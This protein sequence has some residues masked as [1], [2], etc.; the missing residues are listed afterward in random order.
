[1]LPKAEDTMVGREAAGGAT[2]TTPKEA[3]EDM[4]EDM[5][6][7]EVEEEEEEEE[8][9]VGGVAAAAEG[10]RCRAAGTVVG[11]GEAVTTRATIKMLGIIKGEEG[12][13]ATEEEEVEEVEEEEGTIQEASRT[14][15]TMEEQVVTMTT[16]NKMEAGSR[17]EEGVEE[18]VGAG[19][20]EAEQ[21]KQQQE[22]QEVEDGE[23]EGEGGRVLTKEDSLNSSSNM[24]GSTTTKLA[25]IKADTTLVE[26]A[27]GGFTAESTQRSTPSCEP[28]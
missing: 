16:T 7:G 13:V 24:A 14:L 17:R 10:E 11:E 4:T 18:V 9:E 5:E 20:E 25:L 1:M 3:V 12:E 22:Q 26:D 15:A 27:A 19:E 2:I 28:V 6:T 23:G 21:E 8:E